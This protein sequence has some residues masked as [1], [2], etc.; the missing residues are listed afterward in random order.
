MDLSLRPKRRP[1][2]VWILTDQ[3]R[4]HALGYRGN[5]DART[6]NI[7]NLARSGVR[8]DSA[9]AGA[10]WCTPFRGSLLTSLYPHQNGATR[11]PSP[12]APSIPT[13][14]AP[15]HEAGYHTAWI[16]KWHLDGS[17]SRDHY[18]PPDR[19]GGFDYW[20]GY[21]NNNN[22]NECYVFGSEHEEP[23]RLP[24]YEVDS[25]TDLFLGHIARHVT[26]DGRSGETDGY[27]P[28]F[29]VLSVQP[30]HDP[31]VAPTNP[32]YQSSPH[33]PASVTLRANVP[34]VDWMREDARLHYAGYY[35]MVENIDFNVGRIVA[36]LKEL[37][38]DRETY[39]LFFSD[40]G[41]M[42]WSH[43]Q[44]GKSSPWEEAIRIPFLVSRVGGS[45]N[46][47]TGRTDAVLNHVDIAPTTL[48]LCGIDTPVW[49][50]GHDYSSLCVRADAPEHRGAGDADSREEE[51][52]SAYLQQIPRKMHDHSVN[53]AWRGVVTRDGWK[54][55]CTPEND[56]LLFNTSEDPFEQANLA[57]DR[58]FQGEKE[59]CHALLL[60]WIASTGDDFAMPD[61][62]L[63]Q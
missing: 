39:V 35:N 22:Q 41:D 20:M 59:R 2:V 27:Q 24:G 32:A 57:Y 61:I 23:K 6:P 5:P 26:R 34:Y 46:M 30:P 9:V 62:S 17:N 48:G 45:T 53:R 43:G 42:L 21:E 11:T 25:L 49:M 29:A 52:E 37:D 56:W 40:H 63:P 47:K 33:T 4:V 18:V 7:D 51:P 31:Y 54:Y 12:L 16:G 28:F 38:A 8:F 36:R 3:L 13:I 14:T 60:G 15:F 50:N 10:P 58:T 19:R 1:N 44:R 55:A